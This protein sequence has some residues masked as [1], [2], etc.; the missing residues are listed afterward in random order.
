MQ[1]ITTS[2]KQRPPRLRNFKEFVLGTDAIKKELP[3]KSRAHNRPPCKGLLPGQDVSF[4]QIDVG[5]LMQFKVYLKARLNLSDRTI[6]NYLMVIQAVFSQAIKEGITDKKYFPFGTDKIR[7]KV[8]QSQKVGLTKED[9]AKLEAVELPVPAHKV[10]RDL[11]LVSFYFAGMRA[12]DVLQLKWSDFRDGRLHY[13]MDKNSKPGSLKVPDKAQQILE[14]YKPQAEQVKNRTSSTDSHETQAEQA[15]DFV[16]HYLKGFTAFNDTFALKKRI[17]SLVSQIDKLLKNRVAPAA[18][19]KG[20]L[21]MHIARHTFATLAGDKIPIQ[22]L[23][24]LYRHS[25]IKTTLSYQAN[26]IH[27]DA[28]EALDAVVGGG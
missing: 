16:F 7:I 4:A 2:G 8:P 14:R 6:A 12:G 11:W 10:A 21:S 15:D 17:A 19:L 26:F 22:M 13:V 5:I 20:K 25:D 28:D 24:K 18:K 23:Q 27:K 3:E 9:V 1:A